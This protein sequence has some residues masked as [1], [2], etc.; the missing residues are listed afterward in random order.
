MSYTYEQRKRPPGQTETAPVRKSN[1]VHSA[2]TPAAAQSAHRVD[3][4]DAM[5]AK[6]ESAF[7]ADLSDV[8]LYESQA[9]ADAGA[10]A[11]TQGSS[12]AFAPGKLDFAS[13][14]GQSLLG[15]EL[16]HV[17]SQ[18]RG[19]VTG[20]GFLN[21]HALEARADREGAMAAAGQQVY[22]G[23]VTGALS[24]AAPA[25]SAAAPMQAKRGKSKKAARINEPKPKEPAIMS[26]Y[27]N[28]LEAR[29][30]YE[31][32]KQLSKRSDADRI[33]EEDAPG[34]NALREDDDTDWVS[35]ELIRSFQSRN[36][37]TADELFRVGAGI[38]AHDHK[39]G[40]ERDKITEKVMPRFY[41][42]ELKKGNKYAQDD[43]DRNARKYA[44]KHVPKLKDTVSKK[45]RSWFDQ[46]TRDPSV[47]LIR[48]LYSRKMKAANDLLAYRENLG[49][50]R[51]G[52]DPNKLDFETAASEQ[53]RT[54]NV[55]DSILSP[56]LMTPAFVEYQN[57]ARSESDEEKATID[58]AMKLSA[59]LD[60]TDNPY[61]A[62][63]EGKAR[64][65]QL[66]EGNI[67]ALKAI[68]RG[69]K[70]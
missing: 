21:D 23:P 35:P 54:L 25:V 12:I 37:Q 30:Y 4:P 34:S 41:E 51:P 67:K 15:H 57:H 69:K 43:A 39:W 58:R 29:D 11:V 10:E 59:A 9:V 50:L 6:M 44:L 36:D 14:G 47:D 2:M 63:E 48:S 55:Y 42:E 40:L 17:V 61:A 16:S 65:S 5:R 68:Y 20:S 60:D 70:K 1:A 33:R 26:S 24:S 27:R 32:G 22:S 66:K 28:M 3:L 53:G 56:M 46:K 7:G 8:K 19:E 38:L 45:E 18:A 52:E 64:R 31:E 62:S 49:R 13:S